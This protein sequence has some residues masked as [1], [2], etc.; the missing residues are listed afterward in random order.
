[1]QPPNAFDL[2]A[3]YEQHGN[4]LYRF[5]LRLSG[6]PQDAE[7]LVQDTFL[8][9]VAG[10]DRFESRSSEATWLFRIARHKVYKLLRRRKLERLFSPRSGAT[11]VRADGIAIAQCV[12]QLPL[13]MREA[14]LLVKVEGFTSAEAG[15]I[16]RAPE[17]TV[18]FRVH[19]AIKQLRTFWDDA[20]EPV[21]EGVPHAV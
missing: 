17:G 12:D 14:F 8:A 5:C 16:L 3:A 19:Q 15:A 1:M 9:A 21:K 6:S 2:D 4:G 11:P 20:D 13:P 18:R 10:H 7:D